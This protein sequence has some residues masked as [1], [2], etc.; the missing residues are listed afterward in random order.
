MKAC[1]PCLCT[2]FSVWQKMTWKCT[3]ALRTT[4]D[5][6]S[7]LAEGHMLLLT[8]ALSVISTFFSLL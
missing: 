4:C 8:A 2:C 6:T 7:P 5:S 3:P 1:P